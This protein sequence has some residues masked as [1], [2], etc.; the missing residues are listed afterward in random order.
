MFSQRKPGVAMHPKEGWQ[1]DGRTPI[2][3]VSRRAFLRR[4]AGAGIVLGSGGLGSLLAA[5]SS[6]SQSTTAVINAAKALPRPDHPVTWPLYVSNKPIKSGLKP[7]KN[8]T[9]KIYNWVAY[10]NPQSLKD[11]GKKYNCKVEVTTFNNM[12]E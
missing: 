9:L 4:G 8:A 12:T 2:P 5:C 10:V 11:F 7:E 6:A 3:G 1:A